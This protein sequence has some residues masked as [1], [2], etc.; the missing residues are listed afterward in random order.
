MTIHQRKQREMS[1]AQM[2][3]VLSDAAEQPQYEVA[4]SRRYVEISGKFSGETFLMAT[5]DNQGTWQVS[6]RAG[7]L[8]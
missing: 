8:A 1:D 4:Y 3:T 7:F 5:R 2:S 6:Y